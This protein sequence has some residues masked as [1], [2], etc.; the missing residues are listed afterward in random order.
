[1]PATFDDFFT[2]PG[3]TL[4]QRR[5]GQLARSDYMAVPLRWQDMGVW[6]CVDARI[7]AGHSIPDHYAVLVGLSY[8]AA[9][10]SARKK[11]GRIDTNALLAPANEHRILEVLQ[12]I[13]QVDWHTNVNDHAAVLVNSVYGRLQEM[14]PLKAR[15]MS[16]GYLT[17]ETALTHQCLAN[18]R[19]AMRWRCH[20]LRLAVIR[21]AFLAWRG[22]AGFSS[23]FQGKWLH[24][25]RCSIAAASMKLQALGKQVRKQCRQDRNAYLSG[26]AEQANGPDPGQAHVAVR[27]LL[28]PRKFRGQGPQPL[29]TLRTP[30]GALCETPE[31]VSAEWR[32]HFASLEGGAVI[33]P[34]A[35]ISECL[36]RQQN[37]GV[38]EFIEHS[39]LPSFGELVRALRA[40]Q[41]HKAAGPDLIPP[42]LCRKFALPL[43]GFLWPVLL[44]SALLGSEPLGF[45]GGTLHHIPKGSTADRTLASSQRGIL[46]Q[47]VFGK[48]LH[49]AFR[50]LPADLFESRAAPHQIG[51][52]RGMSYA[53]GH[54]LSR[55]F[56]AFA[57][58]RC[59]SAAVIFSDLAAAYYAVVREAV[60]GARL[61]QDPIEEISRSLG[62]T[63]A[64]LQEL[65]AHIL[66]E[67]VFDAS[68]SEL[69]RAFIRETHVDTW[70]HVS[71]DGEVVRT[72]RGTRPGSCIADVAF[73]LL[74]EKV[75]ARR[76]RF[77]SNVVPAIPWSGSKEL[78]LFVDKDH[79][80]AP[81]V[82]L[83]DIAYADDH[84]MPRVCSP[85]RHAD[86]VVR[87]VT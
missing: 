80:T 62:L 47:P 18:L 77:D 31:E 57:K 6:S 36:A 61:C 56:L 3:G 29:P 34:E 67:P 40:V 66:T 20:A 23:L 2:G 48:V 7:S 39:E 60:V 8:R 74:F 35:L 72:R 59:I 78:V 28:R 63:G 11:H 30:S 26:L 32:R 52:R 83:Q 53:F 75:L 10:P 65:Q 27:K 24:S 38:V 19:H 85:L 13:P 51:G 76:G 86:S 54:F 22:H 50:R 1:M 46:V 84:A 81:R 73:N 70:F 71:T 16:K 49:K 58:N 82:T 12:G 68:C 14:F 25:L 45:K 21:C 44:K 55:H 33:A 64:D 37:W 17:Q 79:T 5:S 15:R 4:V 43:A 87:C 41:P 69:L 42:A 9:R